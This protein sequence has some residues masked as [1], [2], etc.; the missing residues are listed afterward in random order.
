MQ[1]QTTVEQEKELQKNNKRP[2]QPGKPP[3]KKSKSKR[4]RKSIAIAFLAVALL[5]I[6]TTSYF[7]LQNAQPKT[8]ELATLTVPADNQNLTVRIQAS[9]TVRPIQSVNLSPKTAGRIAQLYVEQGDRVE[10]GQIIA[11]M[12]SDDLKAQVMQARARVERAS[13]QLAQLRAGNRP[14]EIAQARA[15]LEQARARV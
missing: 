8:D 2:P 9:G 13:A 10:D 3:E 12:E 14:Q 15:R 1:R 5:G 4:R 6:G 7:A 11:S